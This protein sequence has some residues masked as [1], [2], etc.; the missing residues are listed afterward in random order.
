MPRGV[1]ASLLT[2]AGSVAGVYLALCALL[3]VAQRSMLYFPTPPRDL[4][5][6]Q[7]LTLESGGNRLRIWQ[8]AV[9]GPRALIY[10]GGNAEDV[11]WNLAPFAAALPDHALFLVNYRGYGGS[12]GS[13]FEAALYE[14]ALAV[15]DY[16]HARHPHVAVM[17][18]SL[19]S[20]VA[21]YLAQARP[22]ERVVLVAPYDSIVN[23]ARG[24]YPAFPVSLL[25]KDRF[26][27]ASRAASV[28]APVLAIVAERDEVIPRR[29]SEALVAAF[30]PGQV[31][32]EV[33]RGAT[34]NSVADSPRYLERIAAFLEK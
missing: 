34:H 18:T 10:F 19:G 9:D 6:A 21:V 24:H 33:I 25:I 2:I 7:A 15:F 31:H 13:P 29:H 30:R 14:D 11:A 26:D 17:G 28:S 1:Q 23:V 5:G 8:R 4:S 32:V 27:S 20:G 3:Y 12:S 22:V 16:V